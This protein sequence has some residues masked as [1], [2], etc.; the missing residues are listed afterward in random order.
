VITLAFETFH[1]EAI[2]E[3]VTS[4]GLGCLPG[5]IGTFFIGVVGLSFISPGFSSFSS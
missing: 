4:N 1:Y 3:I 2:S 5:V